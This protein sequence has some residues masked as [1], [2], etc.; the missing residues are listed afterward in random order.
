MNICQFQTNLLKFTR[1]MY[2]LQS[3]YICISKGSNMHCNCSI[4]F[5]AYAKQIRSTLDFST[6]YVTTSIYRSSFQVTNWSEVLS[7]YVKL[8]GLI[9]VCCWKKVGSHI[10]CRKLIV[11][12]H[13]FCLVTLMYSGLSNLLL[14]WMCNP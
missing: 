5:V 2:I 4:Q 3:I 1:L 13:I 9:F 11:F 10:L 12:F 14:C 8:S 7:A 6:T